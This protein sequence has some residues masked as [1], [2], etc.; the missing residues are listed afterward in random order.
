MCVC[1]KGNGICEENLRETGFT[2][3]P[4]DPIVAKKW[5][6]T[7]RPLSSPAEHEEVMSSRNRVP[8]SWRHFRESP[9]RHS[10]WRR[11]YSQHGGYCC[12]ARATQQQWL[13]AWLLSVTPAVTLQ[14]TLQQCLDTAAAML[15]D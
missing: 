14:L 9:V 12:C 11:K 3:L 13:L 4:S 1:C 8:V 2:L 7:L 15:T 6:K 10:P 5:I